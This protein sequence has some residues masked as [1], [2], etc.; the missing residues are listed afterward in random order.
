MSQDTVALVATRSQVSGWK[1]RAARIE[2]LA[3]VADRH[4]GQTL[5]EADEERGL[6][7]AELAEDL[8]ALVAQVD[9]ED[10]GGDP[11]EEPPDWW[12]EQAYEDR[13]SGVRDD[14]SGCTFGS[15]EPDDLLP[16][17]FY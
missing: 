5:A 11:G 9:P 2:A 3:A 16:P 17:E 10:G 4:S 13:V 1:R 8:I 6:I 7:E 12:L 14:L 15:Y